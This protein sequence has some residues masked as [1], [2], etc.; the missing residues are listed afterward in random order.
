MPNPI[1]SSTVLPISSKSIR[2]LDL[3]P[4]RCFDD[5]LVGL[6][7]V[8]S[9]DYMIQ[10][11]YPVYNALSYVWGPWSSPKDTMRCGHHDLSIT[12][13]CRNALR[14]LRHLY[15]GI[16]IWVD[17]ICIDQS[18]AEEKEQQLPLMKE[19]YTWAEVVYVWLGAESCEISRAMDCLAEAAET[20]YLPLERVRVGRE[21][22]R[23]TKEA[24]F[25]L[26]LLPPFVI[27]RLLRSFWRRQRISGGYGIEE[28]FTNF[29]SQEWF[30]RAWTFQEAVLSS[31]SVILSG[32]KSL[33]W[34][35]LVRGMECLKSIFDD[36][37]R[38]DVGENPIIHYGNLQNQ[39]VI[40]SN[41][42]S[43]PNPILPQAFWAF[44]R[45]IYLWMRIERPKLG[46]TIQDE[47]HISP[48]QSIYNHQKTYA[49]FHRRFVPETFCGGVYLSISHF[50]LVLSIH[51]VPMLALYFYAN[52]GY[53]E[54]S[55]KLGLSIVIGGFVLLSCFW[56]EVIGG[57]AILDL[58]FKGHLLDDGGDETEKI[59]GN[60]MEGVVHTVRQRKTTV[61]H[62]RSFGL[63]GVLENLGLR[64]AKPNYQSSQ[65]QIYH[66][67]LLNL[68]HW[69]PSAIVLLLD[70]GATGQPTHDDEMRDVPSWVP[71]WNRIPPKPT[72][73]G[74]YFLDAS[75]RKMDATPRFKPYFRLRSRSD[76]L[77]VRGHWKGDIRYCTAK[78]QKID[79]RLLETE[80]IET[81]AAIDGPLAIF[82]RWIDAVRS[83]VSPIRPIVSYRPDEPPEYDP[84][85]EAFEQSYDW[86]PS[87]HVIS[88]TVSDTS[89][90]RR[91]DIYLVS[92]QQMSTYENHSALRKMEVL[93]KT[94]SLDYA[95]TDVDI[96]RAA[97]I[98]CRLDHL[99]QHELLKIAARKL[100]EK[101]DI[102]D[103]FVDVINDLA[104]NDRRFFITSEGFLGCGSKSIAVGDRLALVAGVPASLVLRPE[105]PGISDW[106][107]SKYTNVCSAFVLGWMDGSVFRPNGLRT[108]T[109]I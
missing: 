2:V 94:F 11:N 6:L 83:N 24:I 62:D 52:S 44:D 27:L 75:H 34:D 43:P 25:I 21:Q 37:P 103:Y 39:F 101:K 16:A 54:Y 68:L 55:T 28:D 96:W 100:M 23:R 19:I 13:N 89:W 104:T 56:V 95:V 45:V 91:L 40:L 81:L 78:F 87:D 106:Y 70:A 102:L 1:Y 71:N 5:P 42:I 12:K 49:N 63:H 61:P 108:I 59:V 88:K 72:I 32:P 30:M 60:L 4:S 109:L 38:G 67:L 48:P 86:V 53:D 93:C 80:D 66:E 47:L 15:G 41:D 7:R 97:G 14:Q 29:F 77:S 85:A 3:A 65:G 58:C 74:E 90:L 18:N 10:D 26:K 105:D 31:H 73:S 46:F 99:G 98:V 64:F 20:S 9:L 35:T 36:R 57:A 76:E 107:E 17:S 92:T 79:P 82:K 8:I 33:R 51:S 69:S 50:I 22:H 84:S